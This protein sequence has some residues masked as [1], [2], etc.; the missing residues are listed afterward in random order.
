[1]CHDVPISVVTIDNRFYLI[2]GAT[3]DDVDEGGDVA[4]IE[5]VILVNVG[6]WR[7]SHASHQNIDQSGHVADIHAAVAVHIAAQRSRYIYPSVSVPHLGI[8]E[9]AT[10]NVHLIGG[11]DIILVGIA[12]NAEEAGVAGRARGQAVDQGGHAR[13][14]DLV[15]VAKQSF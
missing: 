15:L 14:A 2:S 11:N 12:Q 6:C 7:C 4:D 5:A 3:Q 10:G 1:M 9:F 8:P 13:A